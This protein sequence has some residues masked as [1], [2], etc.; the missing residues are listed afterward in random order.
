MKVDST[1]ITNPEKR[2]AGWLGG[3]EDAAKPARPG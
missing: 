2:K 1:S 3:I